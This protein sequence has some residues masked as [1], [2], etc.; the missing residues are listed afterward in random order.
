MSGIDRRDFLLGAAGV[1]AS[2][3]TFLNGCKSSS[4]SS[5]TTKSNDEP[6]MNDGRPALRAILTEADDSP[7]DSERMRTLIARDMQNDPLPQSIVTA[8]GRAR[9]A[10]NRDEPIQLCMR[11]KIPGF[12]EVYCYAD[13]RGKGYS[14]PETIS[15][16]FEAALTR[17]LRV[18]QSYDSLKPA[19]GEMVTVQ[20]ELDRAWELMHLPPTDSARL[21]QVLAHGLYAGERLALETARRRIARFPTP[22]RDFKFGI[23]ANASAENGTPYDLRLRELFNYATC[24]WYSWKPEASADTDPVDYA[25][26]DASIDWCLKRNIQPKTFGYLYMA[27]GATPEWVRPI[28]T[29]PPTSRGAEA[30]GADQIDTMP[31]REP[32]TQPRAFNPRWGY[33]RVKNL[34]GRVIRQTMAR[35]NGKLLHAEIMNE[36]HDKANL[37]GLNHEQILDMAT[38]AFAAAREGSPTIQR[39]MNHCCMWGEYGRRANPDGSRR[40]SPWQFIKACLDHGVEYETIGLQLYYPQHDL[41]EID[42]MLDRFTQFNKPIQITECATASQDG[43]DDKSMRPRV[44]APGWHGPWTPALQADWA[45]GIYTLCYSKPAFT[46]VGWWDFTDRPGHFWPFGGLLDAQ[47]RPKEAYFRLQSLQKQWGVTPS[48]RSV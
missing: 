2:A 16:A 21:Y 6:T 37:W 48:M 3:T 40:W 41:F 31:N 36:A 8:P 15:F 32:S 17:L 47:L 1:V 25:R 4:K 23:M 27:R 18:Q 33:D 5:I 29:S 39:E 45:E 12:G 46:S 26:M 10:L 35:Y 38:M 34:Y 11:L 43:L 20:R 19:V 9:I 28:E 44:Y 13:G 30:G 14:N 7:L 22:R 24:S 42:R